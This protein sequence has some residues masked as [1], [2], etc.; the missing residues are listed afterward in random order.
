VADETKRLKK[1]FDD[2]KNSRQEKRDK[3]FKELDAFDRGD[4]WNVKNSNM[5]P[6]IPKP[7][8][9]YV[10]YVHTYKTASISVES[11]IGKLRP[12]S[13]TD[14]ESV[15]DLQK[16]YEYLWDKL[17]LK[18]K[19]RDAISDSRLFGTSILHVGWDET[20]LVGGSNYRAEGEITT[21]VIPPMN[22][23]PDPTAFTL[24]DC[25][26]V[27]ISERKTKNWIKTQPLFNKGTDELK[28]SMSAEDRGE[29][30]FRDYDSFQTDGAVDFYTFYEKIPNKDGGYGIKVTYMSGGKVLHVINDLQPATYPFVIL[31]EWKQTHDFWGKSTCEVILDNQKLVNKVESIVA[32]IGTLLSNPIKVV[33]TGSGID[34]RVVSKYGNAS[35]YTFSSNMD[36]KSSI[37][38]VDP[39]AIPASLFRLRE[40]TERA[41]KE[42]AGLNDAYVGNA[43]GSVQ[44]SSGINSLIDRSTIRDKDAMYELE[45]F[46]SHLSALIIKFMTVHYDTK[47]LIRL[48]NTDPNSE[49]EFSFLEFFGSDYA[50]LDFD[51]LIDVT[52]KTAHS[53]AKEAQ[54]MQNLLQ[55]QMQFQPEVPLITMEEAISM[56]DISAIKKDVILK[57][58]RDQEK[59]I[60]LDK[61]KQIIAYSIQ[62]MNSPD[63]IEKGL[64]ID[65]LAESGV[66]L[67]QP[68]AQK[69]GST[70]MDNTQERQAGM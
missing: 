66:Q 35:G 42:L 69:L 27:V 30:L 68:Q 52:T 6:W 50:D 58:M 40:D 70:N 31:R 13:P 39:P 57:R 53:Q 34:P 21:T 43:V 24:E 4:Q 54:D 60:Q 46:V 2:A 3:M 59:Q 36:A 63:A 18:Y 56:S 55:M 22:F 37:T 62:A 32:T 29:V 48:E 16:V 17:E 47:R 61:M 49:E 45:I 8:T 5:P 20:K 67:L 9:N 10:H 26:Y 41:I 33:N 19:V 23:Y 28:T 7:V 12:L 44:T 14:V 15:N 1:L 38:F 25:R 11:L 51:F 64:N 65:Q